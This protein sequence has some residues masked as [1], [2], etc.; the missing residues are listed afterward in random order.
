MSF[1]EKILA[2]SQKAPKIVSTLQTEEATKNALVMPF[3]AALGYDVFNPLEVVPEFT[4]DIGIKKGEKVDYAIMREGETIILIECKKAGANLSDENMNQLTRYFHATKARIAILTNG[5]AYWFFSDLEEKNIMD[6]KPFLEL[7]LLNPDV[8]SIAEVK[9]M[10]K[11]DFDLDVMLNSASELKYK[12]EIKKVISTIAENPDEEFVKLVF[13]RI[14]PGS[15]FRSQQKE[16]FTP[17]V[18]KAFSDFISDKINSRLKSAMESEQKPA[19]EK[20]EVSTSTEPND[21]GIVTT[22]EELEGYRIVKAIAARIVAP[23]RIVHRDTQSYMGILLDDNNRKPVCRLWFN[24][25]QKYLGLFDQ[26]KNET[27]V[28]ISSVEGIYA[29]SEKIIATLSFY[30]GS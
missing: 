6:K 17:I 18:G 25:K 10:A 20:K 24:S 8:G 23:P 13:Q 26:E 14:L 9:K 21:K 12:R 11:D 19:A 1:D 16:F 3:I 4:A 15:H 27:R 29:F 5:S 30:E 22:E 28:P 2:L 7:D